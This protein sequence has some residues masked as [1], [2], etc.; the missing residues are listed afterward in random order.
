VFTHREFLSACTNDKSGSRRTPDSLLAYHVQK[1]HLLRLRRSLYAAVELETDPRT[2]PVDAFL[3]ASKLADDAVLAYHTALEFHGKAYSVHER[4]TYLTQSRARPFR[5]RSQVFHAIPFPREL[6]SRGQQNFDVKALE[7][8]GVSV[9]VTSLERTLVDVLDRP[10]LAGGWEEIWRSL[11]LVEFFA[12]DRVVEYARLLNNA[13]TAAKV[14]FF[15]EQH[16]DVLMVEDKHLQPLKDRRPKSPHY[17]E[18]RIRT[19]CRLVGNWNLVVPSRILDRT[20][21]EVV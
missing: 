9:N 6:V 18:R 16:R 5:F 2:Q 15:L 14:G 10:D 7:R 3:L 1:G 8:S 19:D 21:E 11:D 12:L 20:W 4:L 13:T 17:L